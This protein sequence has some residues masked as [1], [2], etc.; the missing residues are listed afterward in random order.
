MKNDI[1]ILRG[2]AREYA[3]AAAASRNDERRALHRACNDLR[4]IRPVVLIDEIPW[5]Q[6]DFDGSLTCRC[7]C[8]ITLKDISTCRNRPENLV[9]WERTVM[10]MVLNY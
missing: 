7:S 10:E 2:L 9:E 3:A 1:A 8:D 4:M 5:P 6:M